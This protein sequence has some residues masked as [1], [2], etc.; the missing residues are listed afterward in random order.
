MEK[1]ISQTKRRY[2]I[3]DSG[4][5]FSNY[6]YN[7]NGKKI[8]QRKIIT[9]YVDSTDRLFPMVSLKINGKQKG[10]CM[11]NLIQKYFNLSPPD[12]F[13]FYDLTTKNGDFKNLSLKNIA[14]KIR[15]QIKYPYYPQPFYY[16]G[17]II[18]KICGQCGFKKE[19]SNF[20]LQ[21]NS[22]R[23]CNKTYRNICEPCR[24]F[25]QWTAIKA[26]LKRLKRTYNLSK[27]WSKTL[28]GESYYKKYRKVAYKNHHE[29]LTPHYIACSLRMKV[30]DVTNILLEL[31]RKRIRLRR[32]INKMV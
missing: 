1:Y 3:T 8:H 31:S 17:K 25:K 19:I 11:S 26:D 21:S 6:R 23:K 20:N 18:S 28:R 22:R 32:K 2:S 30:G 24:S 27:K 7:K 4:V 16:R 29:N 10:F 15:T 13:H 5:V 12:K 9:Q 14:Y